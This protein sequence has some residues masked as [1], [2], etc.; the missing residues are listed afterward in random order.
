MRNRSP[1]KGTNRPIIIAAVRGTA[2][3]CEPP[4]NGGLFVLRFEHRRSATCD[5]EGNRRGLD[6]GTLSVD[7]GSAAVEAAIECAA[8]PNRTG[9]DGAHTGACSPK[10][11]GS[12]LCL[13]PGRRRV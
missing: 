3:L 8:R 11:S 10:P 2:R 12:E 1:R 13:F 4:L 9:T 6:C 5:A 7:S